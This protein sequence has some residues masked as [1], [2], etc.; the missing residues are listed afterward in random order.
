MNENCSD[1]LREVLLAMLA[2][3]LLDSKVLQRCFDTFLIG[4]NSLLFCL[5]ITQGLHIMLLPKQSSSTSV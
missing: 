1:T 5:N 3:Y 2:C 4:I